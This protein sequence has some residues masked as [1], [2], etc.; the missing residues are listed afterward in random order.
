MSQYSFKKI[1]N[2]HT[3]PQNSKVFKNAKVK[4]DLEGSEDGNIYFFGV[5]SHGQ[6]WKS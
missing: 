1:K 5:E 6:S 2:A 3:T 4:S